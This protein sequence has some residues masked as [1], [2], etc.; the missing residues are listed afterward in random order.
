M[1]ESTA[2]FDM[3]V[4]TKNSHHPPLSEWIFFRSLDCGGRLLRRNMTLHWLGHRDDSAII[5]SLGPGWSRRFH[6]LSRARYCLQVQRL[7]GFSFFLLIEP[8]SF[9]SCLGPNENP[10]RMIILRYPRGCLPSQNPH[11]LQTQSHS[12]FL[13][14]GLVRSL[15]IP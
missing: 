4:R 2:H 14:R 7:F 5:L 13:I 1:R 9:S 6:G 10:A 11:L 12:D 3:Q 15:E 8:E